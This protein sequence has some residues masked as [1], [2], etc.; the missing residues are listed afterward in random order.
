MTYA[1]LVCI[2]AWTCK[3]CVTYLFQSRHCALRQRHLV[4]RLGPLAHW[5]SAVAGYLANRRSLGRAYINEERILHSLRKHLVSAHSSDL[6]RR[7]FDEW[8]NSFRHRHPNTRYGNE[9]AVYNLCR[10]RRR[11]E[12]R[13]YLPDLSSF[14]RRQPHPLPTII[15]PSHVARLLALASTLEP[16]RC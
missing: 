14:A 11:S 1:A 10:Y 7:L 9:R 8:R 15:E 5:D 3:A 4:H 13:C 12:P 2:C 6:D 16:V